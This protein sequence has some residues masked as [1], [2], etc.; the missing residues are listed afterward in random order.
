MPHSTI[1]LSFDFDA[2]SVWFGYPQTTPAMLARG[3]TDSL[4]WRFL[5]GCARQRR[6]R[7]LGV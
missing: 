4:C 7:Q 5:A 2:L 6:D 1:C 3:R